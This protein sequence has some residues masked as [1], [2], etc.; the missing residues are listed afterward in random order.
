MLLRNLVETF[1]S[2]RHAKHKMNIYISHVGDGLVNINSID[3]N[4]VFSKKRESW[5]LRPIN[6]QTQP[7][8]FDPKS[9][10]KMEG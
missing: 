3:G 10:S 8:D 7:K 1:F 5:I 4:L 2:V 9:W 6:Q